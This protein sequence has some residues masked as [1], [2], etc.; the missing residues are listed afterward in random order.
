MRFLQSSCA[1]VQ[2]VSRILSRAEVARRDGADPKTMRAELAD[3]GGGA[4]VRKV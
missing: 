2:V 3:E 1:C 4:G